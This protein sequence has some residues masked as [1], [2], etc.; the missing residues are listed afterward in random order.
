MVILSK[1]LNLEFI[2]EKLEIIPTDKDFLNVFVAVES[3]R[4]IFIMLLEYNNNV[5]VLNVQLL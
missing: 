1:K 4:Q 3:L 2:K 5:V